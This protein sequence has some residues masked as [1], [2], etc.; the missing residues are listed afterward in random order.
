MNI[1]VYFEDIFKIQNQY[2]G[3]TVS[4]MII[5]FLR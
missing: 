5:I 1:R 3:E 2:I 4:T